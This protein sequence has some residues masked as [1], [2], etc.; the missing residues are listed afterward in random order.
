MIFLSRRPQFHAAQKGVSM[1]R[2][3][4]LFALILSM[5]VSGC[6]IAGS[7]QS[8]GNIEPE[9]A[10]EM[11]TEAE[12]AY[13]PFRTDPDAPDKSESVHVEADAAGNPEEVTVEVTL[14]NP[15]DGTGI[16]DT[17]ILSDIKN[18]EGDEEYTLTGND[19]T[20]ED[21]G[22]DIKYEGT[23]EKELPVTVKVTCFLDDEE[24]PPQDLAGKSGHVKI[25]FDYENHT[26]ETVTVK[27]A[28]YQVPIP[29][30]AVTAAFL[31]T[32]SFS[33][34][35]AEN[36]RVMKMDD[37]AIVMGIA[38]PGLPKA[39]R[40]EA[41]EPAEDIEIPDFVEIEADVQDFTLDFTA[42]VVTNGLLEDLEEE[43]LND[44]MEM[45][46]GMDDLVEAID[47]M[48][49]GTDELYDGLDEVED[50]LDQYADGV[51]SLDKGISSLADGISEMSKQKQQLTA[52]A[53]TL[54]NG[55]K[56]LSNNVEKLSAAGGENAG[57]EDPAALLK[58]MKN[59]SSQAKDLSAL[60]EAAD[61][62]HDEMVQFT[63][64]AASCVKKMKKSYKKARKMLNE[65]D[66]SSIDSEATSLAR[67]QAAAAVEDALADSG[68]SEKKIKKIKKK[69][70]KSIDLTGV[71]DEASV[72]IQEA[73]SKLYA[74]DVDVPKISWDKEEA[75]KLLKKMN[76]Q[77]EII[78]SCSDALLGMSKQA[79]G[80]GQTLSGLAE[81][82]K[83]L[84][85]GSDELASGVKAFCEGID[86]IDTGAAQ[87]K[88]GS[89]SLAD[90]GG[91]L[92]D[93][94][95]EMK[96]GVKEMKDGLT[97]FKE[98]GLEDL[99]KT[100]G[101][102]FKRIIN[103]MRALKESDLAYD[104]YSGLLPGK[105]GEV[106]FLIETEEIKE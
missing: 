40:L 60:I 1:K 106:R 17:T 47:D 32:D 19:L 42:T 70:K 82:V 15:G 58:A 35:K 50:Y 88:S 81:G 33:N 77:M 54:A 73:A 79:A 96:D 39:L 16:P 76:Q 80:L 22:G 4:L 74:P 26:T 57:N 25:R 3:A 91:K 69:V 28:E 5:T 68:L 55:M 10:A 44:L 56:E 99:K 90:A 48:T 85:D 63:E 8:S 67:K 66:L 94:M 89:G 24:I 83:A 98:D 61:K 12:A 2:N 86:A 11:E 6:G 46:D 34:I 65:I 31:P 23:A 7:S 87:L 38:F 36:G 84:S 95:G 92:T 62:D 59:L 45:S 102:E 75:Q 30:T 104:N 72:R 37:Q 101:P 100:A 97:E 9:T 52:G 53:D 43:D 71:S 41:W 49:E 29:F 18:K 21:H 103:T 93:G 78:L 27:G 64:D 51:K 20:W 14:K 13:V 105:T